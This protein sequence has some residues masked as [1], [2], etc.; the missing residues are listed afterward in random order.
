MDAIG[1]RSETSQGRTLGAT[2][3]MTVA[4]WNVRSLRAGT[5]MKMLDG[6]FDER[7]C[8]NLDKLQYIQWTMEDKNIWVMALQDTRLE[9]KT[10]H[11]EGGWTLLTRGREN[12]KDAR[13]AHGV[14]LLLSPAAT[15]VWKQDGQ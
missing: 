14:A 12:V 5:H 9:S 10:C 6:K 3:G 8:Y 13:A 7:K 1:S 4:S 15:R 11:L 2:V